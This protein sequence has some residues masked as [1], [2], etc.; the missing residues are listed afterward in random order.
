MGGVAKLPG[1]IKL[2]RTPMSMRSRAIGST[3]PFT[4]AL[5]D[6][7]GTWPTCPSCAA[8]EAV[9]TIAPRSQR[10]ERP[11]LGGGG[12]APLAADVED[13]HLGATPWLRPVPTPKRRP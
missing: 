6:P 7:Y 12:L 5:A 11:D 4:P 8:T 13:R 9:I 10:V 3:K 2:M 1:M